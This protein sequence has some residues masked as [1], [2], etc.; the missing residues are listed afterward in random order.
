[1]R[2]SEAIDAAEANERRLQAD[3]AKQREDRETAMRQLA[4]V[5]VA[6]DVLQSTVDGLGQHQK[7][8]VN[9]LKAHGAALEPLTQHVDPSRK[10]AKRR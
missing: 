7:Q 6:R 10:P 1:M 3:L 5:T 8:V 2:Y 9:Q 4:D